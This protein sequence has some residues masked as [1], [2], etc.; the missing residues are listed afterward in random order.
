M[1]WLRRRVLGGTLVFAT[2]VSS[3]ACRE[4][5]GQQ[6]LSRLAFLLDQISERRPE[7]RGELLSTLAGAPCERF[8]AL[9]DECER[10][11]RK[12]KDALA[13]VA[14]LA[15]SLEGEGAPKLTNEQLEPLRG[16]IDA[17]QEIIEGCIARRFELLRAH[18]L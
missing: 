1:T 11:Y 15:S 5:S 6:E 17:A 8:C 14:Q 10:G 12:Q 13:R 7:Q 16:E 9:R 3:S 18:G 4:S 2:L